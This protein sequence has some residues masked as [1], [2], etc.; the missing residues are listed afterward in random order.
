M[1][2]TKKRTLLC[3]AALIL[4]A[5]MMSA[6]E[7]RAAAPLTGTFLGGAAESEWAC[8]MA[9]DT[10]GNV[11][12]AGYT[13]SSDF[14]TTSGAYSTALGGSYDAFI[15]KFDS[16]MKNLLAATLYGG[17]SGDEARSLQLDAAGNVYIAGITGSGDLPTTP[18]A[19]QPDHR[20]GK[21]GTDAFVAKF[22]SD[23][24]T[25]LAATYLSGSDGGAEDRAYALALDSSGSVYVTGYTDAPNFPVTA[26]TYDTG[27]GFISGGKV[28]VVKLDG[29]LGS[30]PAGTFLGDNDGG[31]S[32]YGIITDGAG[33]VFIAGQTGTPAFPVTAGAYDTTL[34]NAPGYS[35][36]FVAKF[37]A[38][39]K[40]LLASTYLGG[41][42]SDSLG[43]DRPQQTDRVLAL[44]S[45]GNLYVTGITSSQD[46]PVTAGAFSVVRDY[47]GSFVAKFTDD[48]SQL[49]ACTYLCDGSSRSIAIDASDSICVAGDSEYACPVPPGAYQTE[50]DAWGGAYVIKLNSSLTDM[51]AATFLGGSERENALSIAVD[52][53]ENIYIT[54]WTASPDF[55][56]SDNAWDITFN[57]RTGDEDSFVVK[58]NGDL[59]SDDTGT[60][61]IPGGDCPLEA[62]LGESDDLTVLRRLRD[63]R[64]NTGSA[65][66]LVALYYRHAP[67]LAGIL[68]RSPGKKSGLRRL[69]IENLASIETLAAGEKVRIDAGVVAQAVSFLTGLKKHARPE[70]CRAIQSVIVQLHDGSLLKDIGVTVQAE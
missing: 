58:L 45:T 10:D 6:P 62:A 23:L 40:N 66:A 24:K 55:P 68:S 52:A 16:S 50:E 12:V 3:M 22:D 13:R 42:A 27:T 39:L 51:L 35:D 63:K 57:S 53:S 18:G 70:T 69:V 28:F 15:A 37:D 36:V 8:S 38:D 48:L 56:V 14:P 43:Y 59:S 31:Q 33:N 30:M 25:L 11:Y 44:D 19:F 29:N 20:V 7:S 21:V 1:M 9:L 46:F 2:N 49:L 61:T 34:N 4:A 47:G 5:V 54:G 17:S 64:L 60:T 67:E 41:S 26:G 65:P 32:C